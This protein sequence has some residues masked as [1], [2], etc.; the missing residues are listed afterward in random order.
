[1][2]TNGTLQY[3]IQQPGGLDAYGEPIAPRETW[4]NA[5]A[6]SIKTNSD[7]RKGAYEDGEFR[8]AS[9]IVLLEADAQSA[10]QYGAIKRVRLMR[11]AEA[12]GEYRVACSE[13]LS[14]CGRFQLT[15]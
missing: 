8:V 7:N 5:I 2:R 10:Q 15:V 4:S 6:C 3:Q 1:M 9:F 14:T 13:Y 12:L 11:N